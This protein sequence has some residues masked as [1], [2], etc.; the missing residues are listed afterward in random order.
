[1]ATIH[2]AVVMSDNTPPRFP[3]SQYHAQVSENVAIGTSVTTVTALSRSTLTY[4]LRHDSGDG[5]FSINQYSGVI[6]TRKPIDYE[7]N[8]SFTLAVAVGDM[9]GRE[10]VVKVTV[11]VLDCNDNSPEFLESG[12]HGSVREGAPVGSV[13]TNALSGAALQLKCNADEQ[14][15]SVRDRGRPWR[16]GGVAVVTVDILDEN[17]N[18]PRFTQP[19]HSHTLPDTHTA[20]PT[21]PALLLLPTYQGVELLTV[22]AHDPDTNQSQLR[23]SLT[24]SSG[25][26]SRWALDA[27]SGVL[28][29]RNASWEARGLAAMKRQR[30]DCGA[31]SPAPPSDRYVA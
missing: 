10:A 31:A 4:H 16:W 11:T 12:Y 29:V 24:D 28:T 1:M 8:Q 22:S 15:V 21:F 18:P 17:D 14:V 25:A 2:V 3:L 26:G 20:P 7:A 13:V 9:A 27:S 5:T 23:F 6:V 30:R 19:T